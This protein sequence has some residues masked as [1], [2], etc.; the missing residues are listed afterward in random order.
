MSAPFMMPV[1]TMIVASLPTSRTTCG[2]RWNGM[3]ARSSWRPP[4][5]DSTTPSTP[6]S[7]SRFE[8]STFCT[9]LI[10]MFPGHIARITARSS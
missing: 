3:G 1:S 9:P 2:S 8:S 4:W 6:R 10:T 5:F 7:T